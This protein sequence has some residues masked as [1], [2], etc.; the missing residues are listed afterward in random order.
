MAL[1]FLLCYL[2]NQQQLTNTTKICYNYFQEKFIAIKQSIFATL[3]TLN[4]NKKPHNLHQVL[5]RL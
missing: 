3:W 1:D 2:L 5:L 4:L